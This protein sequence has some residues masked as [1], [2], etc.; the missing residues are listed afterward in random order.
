[1][2]FLSSGEISLSDKMAEAGKKARAGQ[3]I[4]LLDL[5]SDAGAGYGVFETI[6]GCESPKAFGDHLRNVTM[7]F[8]GAP[9]RAFLDQITQVIRSPKPMRLIQR[10]YDRSCDSSGTNLCKTISRLA[11]QVRSD[12]R[13]AGLVS[14]RRR[15][16]SQPVSD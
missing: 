13:A 15:V 10:H 9:L 3:Q 2:L 11:H 1:M 12:R 6:H 8:H 7:E 4:R 5:P 16:K 14:S